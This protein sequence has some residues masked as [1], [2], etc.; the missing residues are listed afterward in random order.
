MRVLVAGGAG[1]VGSHVLRALVAAGWEAV[2]L[3]NLS[4]GHAAAVA[5]ATGGRAELVVGNV[6]DCE[7]VRDVLISR[8]IGAV[9]HCA[10]ASL[11]GESMANPS[12]YWRNNVQEAIGLL[13]AMVLAGV[14]KIV[15]SSSAA[16]YGE[17]VAVPIEETHPKSPTSTYGMTKLAIEHMLQS[18]SAAHSM[19][20][21]SLRYFNA[22]GA[23]EPGDIGEAH[24]PETHLIPIV[25][26]A[27]LE[28]RAEV[29]VFGTDYDTP[30]GTCV[31]DYI[32]VSDLADAHVLALQRM[33]EMEMSGR[34]ARAEAFN[35]GSGT[36]FTV[37]QV[38]ECARE[39]VGTEATIRAVDGQRRPGDPAVLVASSERAKSELGW[40]PRRTSLA[41]IVQSAWK[42]HRAHPHGYSG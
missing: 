4:T 25:L 37:R 26:Q 28:Q 39:V 7:L 20:C 19:R 15:F 22:A 21:V 5:R 1:Y 27:A 13:D 34:A 42:W 18:Y 2:V 32:H 24:N 36:G 31:R 9:V 6:G 17:P 23:D 10:A 30:D 16:V 12:K 41:E 35:L 38:I 40:A 14:D 29:R 8:K 3:D 33:H 11:V